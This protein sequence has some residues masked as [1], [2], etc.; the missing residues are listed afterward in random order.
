MG[1]AKRM[2]E[3]HDEAVSAVFRRLRKSTDQNLA[4][5]DSSH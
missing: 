5:I 1:G 4:F 3:E 2:M